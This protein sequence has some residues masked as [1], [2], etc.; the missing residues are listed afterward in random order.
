VLPRVQ[1]T[2]M[3]CDMVRSLLGHTAS[4]DIVPEVVH[5]RVRTRVGGP[6]VYTYG[7]R[8]RARARVRMCF[9]CACRHLQAATGARYAIITM[10]QGTQYMIAP[11]AEFDKV[12]GY[13][14]GEACATRDLVLDLWEALNKRGLKLL[15]YVTQSYHTR[16]TTT[17]G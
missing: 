3:P 2:R 10:M 6:H 8:A 4:C 7:V 14:P 9:V 5:S 1:R 15:L 13:A 11:N 17:N 12:T 16:A